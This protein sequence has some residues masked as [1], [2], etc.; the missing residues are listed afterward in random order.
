MHKEALLFW[1]FSKSFK[2]FH[3][4]LDSVHELM[5]VFSLT[6]THGG[7]ILIVM[8]SREAMDQLC[9]GQMHG[10]TQEILLVSIED[11]WQVK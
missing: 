9:G 3:L 5:S 4:F 10:G 1:N 2:F 8:G 7:T 11:S 6:L